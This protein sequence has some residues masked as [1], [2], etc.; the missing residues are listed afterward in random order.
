MKFRRLSIQELEHL[1]DDFIKFLASNTITALDWEKTKQET[2]QKAE[3]L[4]EIFSD[5][6][7][8]KVYSK[9]ELLE[10]IEP[11]SIVFFKF[12]DELMTIL[13]I[14]SN[15]E[16]DF[17]QLTEINS[18]MQISAFRQTKVLEKAQKPLEIHRLVESGALIG[19]ANLFKTLNQM[20]E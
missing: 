9:I 20:V 3:E 5:V 6:V 8:E 7:M 19:R 13:G 15:A 16:I 10:L 4:I 1:K 12:D 18:E 17:T 14:N 2:P 11:K